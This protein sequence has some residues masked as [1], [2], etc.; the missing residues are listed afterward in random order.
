MKEYSLPAVE[1]FQWIRNPF[2]FPLTEQGL[3]IKYEELIEIS[4]NEGM[5]DIHTSVPL[6]IFW[7][8]LKEEFPHISSVAVNNL[9]PFPYT[10][11][12]ETAF[13]R[14]AAAKTQ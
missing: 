14:Y 5:K 2:M 8:G 9:L 1:G 13:P 12:R 6:T 3:L 4:T 10:Y 7:A 11:L